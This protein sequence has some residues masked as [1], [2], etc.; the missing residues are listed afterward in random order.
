MAFE[1]AMRKLTSRRASKSSR[2]S[3]VCTQPNTTGT[4]RVAGL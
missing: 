2:I 1:I 4:I 3:K